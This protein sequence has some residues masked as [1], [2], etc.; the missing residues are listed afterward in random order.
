MLGAVPVGLT[1]GKPVGSGPAYAAHGPR[2]GMAPIKPAPAA[3]ATAKLMAACNVARRRTLGAPPGTRHHT[4][5]CW[6]VWWGFCG[7][8]HWPRPLLP[9]QGAAPW[10]RVA[11]RR[12]IRKRVPQGKVAHI[13]ALPLP[14]RLP[15]R[16]NLPPCTQ[17]W[18]GVGVTGGKPLGLPPVPLPALP[19]TVPVA[20]RWQRGPVGVAMLR[21][22]MGLLCLLGWRGPLGGPR[23]RHHG[24]AM[25][26]LAPSLTKVNPHP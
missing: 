17:T 10:P 15:G 16:A 25:P 4:A 6:P 3:R 9:R 7:F 26:R 11:P 13:W 20:V 18:P 5:N 1:G 24:G 22:A 19:A 12:V 2:H 14:G 21:F 23:P 8:G